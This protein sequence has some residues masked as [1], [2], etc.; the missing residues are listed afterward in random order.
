ML[1]VSVFDAI[2]NSVAQRAPRY[3]FNTEA[4]SAFTTLSG[5]AN[6]QLSQSLIDGVHSRQYRLSN[7]STV[8]RLIEERYDD[9][10]EVDENLQGAAAAHS[11]RGTI[12]SKARAY[13]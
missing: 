3:E 2:K 8:E 4:D 11:L 13:T 12:L 9:L 6:T 10:F 5:V 7:F 1:Y